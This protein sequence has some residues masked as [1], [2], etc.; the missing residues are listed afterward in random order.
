MNVRKATLDDIDAITALLSQ[1][2]EVH[3]KARPDLFVSGTVKYNKSELAD[4]ISNE[5]T[6]VFVCEDDSLVLGHAFT[7][8]TVNTQQTMLK[9]MK[10]MYI[11]DICVDEKARRKNVGT[12]LYDHC[13]EYARKIGCY[14][15]TLN[16]WEGN[17]SAKQFYQS[18]GMRVRKTTLEQI[19]G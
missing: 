11:D 8:I 14:D 3:A 15:V 7:E 6:P 18:M 12:M 9:G 4:I 2:L 1:V 16:V 17:D 5:A 19:L 10:S 13:I